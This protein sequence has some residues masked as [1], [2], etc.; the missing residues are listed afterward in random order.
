MFAAMADWMTVALLQSE[1]GKPPQRM[2]LAHPSIAPY[3]VF[4]TKNEIDILISI[5]NDREWRILAEKVLGNTEL[6][7][8]TRFTRNVDRVT[9]RAE[10]DAHVATAFSAR[11][12]E[13]LIEALV[14]ADIAFA[15]VTD[16]AGL[17]RHPHLER[18][19]VSTP[20]GPVSYPRPAVS[21]KG[22]R[23]SY[24]AVPALGEHTASIR[25]EFGLVIGQPKATSQ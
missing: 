23:R 18:I 17:A 25:A 20:S 3:G 21:W 14:A 19:A 1:S 16:M 4:K 11:S 5:Q 10:T 13:N 24:G 6:A 7:Q 22:S 9:R 8:D 12:S 2:G 15:P